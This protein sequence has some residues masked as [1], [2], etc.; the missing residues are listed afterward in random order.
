[1]IMESKSGAQISTRAFLQSVTILF[2]LMLLAGFLTLLLPA[3]SYTRFESD[4]RQV[5]DPQSFRFVDKPGYP[6]WRWFTAPLE[7]LWGPD[8]VI[9]ITIIIFLLMV[10][11]SFAVLDKTGI[12]AATLQRLVQAFGSRKYLLLLVISFFFMLLGAFFGIFEEVVP[13]VP[14]MVALS[15]SLGWDALV[16][17]GMSILATNMGFSAALTNPF[18]IGVAQRLAGL[19]LFSGAWFRLPIF[20]VMYLLLAVFLVRYAR[21]IEKTP[22]ISLVYK[23]DQPGQVHRE[24][25]VP[26][27]LLDRQTI[28][29][30]AVIWLL[31]SLGLILAVLVSA[32]FV[33]VLSDF[34]LPLVG[35]LFFIGGLGAGLLSGK[36]K[37]IIMKALGEGAL[38]IAPAIPLI[39]MASSI[40]YI[41]AEGGILDSI[42]HNISGLFTNSSSFAAVVGIFFLV[43]L[44][45]FFVSSGSAKAF[46]LMPIVLPLADLV[47]VTRQTAVTA[48]CFGDGFTNLAYPTNPVLL[49]C[50]GLTVV[51]YPKWIKWTLP[52]WLGVLLVALFFMGLGVAIRLGPF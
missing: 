23:E 35:L 40:K 51:S 32:P 14:I 52:L 10:G 44:I 41:I 39:L 34:S 50:L 19:P 29:R 17:L 2:A 9:I 45:E 20:V 36:P 6:A 43:L 18:T 1:M 48:Y 49:I 46:L 37:E 24:S 5:I 25:L 42:L 11:V 8:A 4:G 30:R 22:Q 15:Y 47:S 16:G 12:L 3:G 26:G 31:V 21:R 27:S 33:S 28:P 13:L 38:G 7:V